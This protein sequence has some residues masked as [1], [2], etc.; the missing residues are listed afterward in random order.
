MFDGYR[1]KIKPAVT[2]KKN[3]NIPMNKII[4]K[5]KNIAKN[6]RVF[7]YFFPAKR[8]KNKASS[9]KSVP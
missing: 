5:W 2:E 3:E 7:L 4:N 6:K 9:N 1:Y 8:A